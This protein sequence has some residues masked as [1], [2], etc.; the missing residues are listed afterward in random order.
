[1]ASRSAG[2]A[3]LER[4][5]AILA[6]RAIYELAELIPPADLSNGGRR[7]HYPEFMWLVFEALLS[8]YGS[9]RRVEAELSH[10]LVW[11]LLR[12]NVRQRFR[13]DRSK[14]L[15][16]APMRR[17]HYLY[18][19]NRYL[20]DSA[21]FAVL[22][23]T[24]REIAA[25]QACE[26]GLLDPDG[27]GSWTHPDLSRMLHADGKVITPLYTAKPGETRLNPTTG[28]LRSLRHEPDAGLHVEGDG[29]TAWGVKFVLVA[30]RSADVHGRIILDAEWVPRP[31]GEAHTAIGC[32]T[33]LAPLIPGA[34]GVIYDTALR[35]VHHQTLLRDLG[36][37]PV[38]R[39]SAARADD[40]RPRRGAGRRVPKSAHLEDKTVGTGG[41]KQTV[42][43][44]ARDGA[45]GIGHLTE[46]GEL[47]F[48]ELR[49]VR[50]HRNPDKNGKYRWYNDYRL[51]DSLGGET[52]TVRLH[53]TDADRARRLN[54]P[55]NVRPI[56]PTDPD[57][58]RLY[59]RR[60]DAE[61]INR[62]LVDTLWLGRAHSLGHARQH[63]NLLGYALMVNGLALH[64]YQHRAPD[65]IAA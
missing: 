22:A 25:R 40:N 39:V 55:E 53:G 62:N 31:G 57:F 33:R 52:L 58:A 45:V 10:P 65:Q 30:A 17:H 16:D 36:L 61:S 35:G 1:M 12:R 59:P 5:E 4:V 49:R 14:W 3:A 9:A 18:A 26:L 20:T 41:R 54:R 56:P 2:V 23:G 13:R 47:N 44:Y 15:P 64:R 46:S 60:N 50:T 11:E 7:R 37:I 8:V 6:N 63:L 51:P 28:E 48:E 32:F 24:H 29:E 38:N 19:R 43:L 21:V 27:L 42:A 34:Q